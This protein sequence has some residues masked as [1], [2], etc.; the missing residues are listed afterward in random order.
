[1]NTEA[2]TGKLLIRMQQTPNPQALKYVLNKPVKLEDKA[3]FNNAEE[4]EE[5]ILIHSL[6]I[7]PGVTQVH[8]FEN[9]I[10]VTF[11]SNIDPFEKVDDVVSIIKMRYP[12]HNPAFV[13]SGE[14]IKKKK[15][16]DLSPEVLK[17][18]EILDRT[19]RP[20][21]QAD[22]GDLE[23]V[24]LKGKDLEIRYEGA[25]GTCPSATYG[26][27]HAIENILQNEYDPDMRVL[28]AD[29]IY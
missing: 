11:D 8:L 24:S 15:R 14:A 2:D 22:G 9:V 28:L 25:C 7:L 20:G 27:L 12:V 3:T 29:P 17:I 21:L 6:M 5:H 18:E 13:A 4:A 26:T 16:E 19:I 10:T 23:I 1:M